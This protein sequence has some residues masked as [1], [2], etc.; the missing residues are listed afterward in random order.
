MIQEE[1]FRCKSIT[2]S[3]LAFS[4]TN[5]RRREP[6]D[7]RELVQSVLDVTQHLQNHR[8]KHITFEV[9]A[10]RVPGGR[11]T[12][13]ANAEEI[14]SVVLNLVTNALESM[15]EGGHLVIRLRQPGD[16]AE[17]QF[18]DNGC[19][20]TAEV[21]ENI[22]EPFFTRSR[23][24]KGTG[25]GLTISHRIIHQHGGEIEVSSPGP[26]QGSTFVVRLPV[27]PPPQEETDPPGAD[28]PRPGEA[29]RPA[30]QAA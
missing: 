6:T 19:G 17:L 16:R 26:G 8:G 5:E 24:G 20:M 23:T 9:N 30:G 11:I 2:E 12:A 4:R 10:E 13:W 7:L 14:K 15:D 3:L 22:F 21:L 27:H 29:E 28:L 25:L 1:A 18:T